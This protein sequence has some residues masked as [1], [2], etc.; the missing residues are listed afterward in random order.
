[1]RKKLS[2]NPYNQSLTVFSTPKILKRK[3]LSVKYSSERT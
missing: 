3:G 2:Q 1:M